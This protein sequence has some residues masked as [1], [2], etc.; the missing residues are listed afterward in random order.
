MSLVWGF[1]MAARG[2]TDRRGSCEFWLYQRSPRY[3][4]YYH[5]A[6]HG[7]LS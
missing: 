2:R 7:P 5:E 6:I 1:F 3:R 4:R